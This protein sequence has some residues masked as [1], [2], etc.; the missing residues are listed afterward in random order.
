MSNIANYETP[1]LCSY[2]EKWSRQQQTKWNN[3]VE[4]PEITQVSGAT[5]PSPNQEQKHTHTKKSRKVCVVF[6]FLL[7]LASIPSSV[8]HSLNYWEEAIQLHVSPSKWKERIGASLQCLACLGL[9]EG[10]IS[11]LP[12][13]EFRQEWKHSFSISGWRQLKQ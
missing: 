3:F 9:H 11:V 12:D 8:Q 5:E 2:M 7:I 6:F 10:F 13:V 1:G 4:A